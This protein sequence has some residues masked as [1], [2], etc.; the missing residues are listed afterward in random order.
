MQED[1]AMVTDEGILHI[2]YAPS[3]STKT[4]SSLFQSDVTDGKLDANAS[5]LNNVQDNGSSNEESDL[6]MDIAQQDSELFSKH[7]R[8]VETNNASAT[9]IES[10]N[11]RS[12]D[13]LLC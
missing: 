2:W 1:N 11:K 12:S 10:S 9:G 3:I 7:S 13:S 5:G 8:I 4:N 6:L